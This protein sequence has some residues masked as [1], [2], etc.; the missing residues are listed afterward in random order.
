MSKRPFLLGACVFVVGTCYGQS[1]NV[2]FAVCAVILFG[3]GIFHL[4]QSKNWKK[5]TARSL[6]LL[7]VFLLSAIHINNEMDFREQELSH[8]REGEQ[9]TLVGEIYKKEK[10]TYQYTYYLKDVFIILSNQ[11]IACNDVMLTYSN[12][13]I[14][15][16]EI[17][18]L[19]GK[20]ELFDS[21]PNE[22]GFNE[23]EFYY[24][25]KIDFS[26]Y[27]AQILKRE[28]A[29]S[30]SEQLYCFRKHIK[31]VYEKSAPK[32]AAGVLSAM[33]LGEKS[34]IDPNIKNLYQQSG[35]SHILAISGLH[36]SLI[37]MNFYR[38]LRKRGMPYI[39]AFLCALLFLICYVTMSGNGVA[40]RRAFGM[41]VVAMFA[42]VIGR[43]YDSLNA[44]GLMVILLLWD[45]PFLLG[46][47]GFVFSVVA[48]IGVLVVGKLFSLQLEKEKKLTP[49][50]R[51][52]NAIYASIA[53]WLTTLPIVAYYYYEV[54]IYSVLL[55]L[56]VI[57][58]LS[59]MFLFG[60][61]GGV[62]GLFFP[63]F[64]KL[65][66]LPCIL[67]LKIYEWLA[68]FS[69]KIPC[70]QI[71][72][73]KPSVEKMVV[74]YLLLTLVCTLLFYKKCGHLKRIVGILALV[75]F[76]FHA[77][78]HS[79]ELS[80]LDV[81]QGDGIC[82]CTDAGEYI[83]IDGGS[84]DV[85]QVGKYRILPFLK[86]NGIRHID[87]WFV[88]HADEDHISGLEE[89]LEL[90]YPV[91]NVIISKP[92]VDLKDE[93]TLELVE[94]VKTYDTNIVYMRAGESLV[95]KASKIQCLAPEEEAVDENMED[96][97]ALS[98]VLMYQDKRFTA[99]FTGD[100]SEIEERKLLESGV[101]KSVDFYKV[102]HHGSKYSSSEE[103][104]AQITPRIAV[105]SCGEGN[106]YGHPHKETLERLDEIGSVI[107]TTPEYGAITVEIDKKL[108]V[109]G[110]KQ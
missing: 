29:S 78:K 65:L 14:S 15:I 55:N 54:P 76:F 68:A 109:Y 1:Q 37:G 72:V 96:R 60:V 69:M 56:I 16:G 90:G 94:F 62:V 26:I 31:E 5:L 102:A 21:A 82:L 84:S 46:Y 107:L 74:Y 104:L 110:V 25:Q 97:N 101:C 50:M 49:R 103:F 34:T 91:E 99:L 86:A 3:Y 23:K 7:A 77:P 33:L 17:L 10:K 12:D 108:E 67:L 81:G 73:G 61:V 106:S 36:V 83:F 47:A 44:L 45:N 85:N 32:D 38:F 75:L 40:T 58:L 88:S 20:I 57:P 66:L 93:K 53:V 30:V 4:Y 59:I 18:L 9:Y 6:W 39:V 42:N 79:F 35:I 51:C 100:I 52:L 41:L 22:G 80:V 2:A 95:L 89:I 63:L 48:M 98:L 19:K 27:D 11:R 13:T 87:Y 70:A 24:S 8:V 64:A 92:S 43:S 105:V 71:I 28:G